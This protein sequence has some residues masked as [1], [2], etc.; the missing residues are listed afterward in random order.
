M[1]KLGGIGPIKNQK[2]QE[3]MYLYQKMKNFGSVTEAVNK[4]T[5]AKKNQKLSNPSSKLNS[6]SNT[7]RIALPERQ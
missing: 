3:K 6:N 5:I 2:W 4:M 1:S 7:K